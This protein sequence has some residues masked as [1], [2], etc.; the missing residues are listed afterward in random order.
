ML[1]GVTWVRFGVWILIGVIIYF[2]YGINHS[3]LNKD[4]ENSTEKQHEVVLTDKN[5]NCKSKL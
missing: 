3:V 4:S 5:Q 2:M 1:D